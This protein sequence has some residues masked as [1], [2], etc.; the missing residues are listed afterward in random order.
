MDNLRPFTKF[1]CSIGELPTSYVQSLT[2]E[3]QL[4]YFYNYIEEV[5]LPAINNNAEALQET[6]AFLLELKNYVDNYFNNL[7]VQEEINNKLD[8]MAEAGTLEEIISTYLNAQ[9]VLAFDTLDDLKNASNLI[10]GSFVKTYGYTNLNDGE[11]SFYKIR[12]KTEEDVIDDVNIIE[13]DNELLVAVKM[14]NNEMKTFN[15]ISD[16]KS[17]VN[18]SNG[19]FVKTYGFYSINDGG[20]ALYKIRLKTENDNIDEATIIE[21]TDENI[22]A[23]LIINNSL[24]VKQF[25][26]KGDGTTDD[27]EAIQKAIDLLRVY[28]R[29]DKDYSELYFP[30]GEYII[31]DTL[32]FDHSRWLKL[33]GKATIKGNIAK[34]LI[35]FDNAMFIDFNDLLVI[36]QNTSVDSCC[37]YFVDS[38][39][40]AFN[41]AY[42]KGGDIVVYLSNGNDINF[43]NSSIMN[44]R[45][46][47]YTKS[48]ANNTGNNFVNTQIEEASE[49]AIYFDYASPYYGNYNFKG[50]YIECP[51]SEGVIYVKN[52]MNVS[53]DGCYINQKT[54]SKYIFIVDGTIPKMRV[55]LLNSYVIGTSGEVYF[56]KFLSSDIKIGVSIDNTCVLDSSVTLYNDEDT[57]KSVIA[58]INPEI[59]S[60]YNLTWLKDTN[61]TLDT[62]LGSGTYTLTN[63]MSADSLQSVNVTNGYIYKPVYLEKDVL[64]EI[65]AI[66]KNTGSGSCMI[67]IFNDNLDS[68]KMR[69]ESSLST[70]TKI[71]GYYRPVESAVY[72]I[73]I[74][75]NNTT[76]AEFSGIKL[77]SH[78]ID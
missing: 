54:P 37:L 59:L 33:Y 44:G 63:S 48:G 3:E 27:T 45:I 52:R 40:L 4:L 11:G 29:A 8:D 71:T 66:V 64:Y 76:N 13:L 56:S 17:C 74:R 39:V 61:D 68:R 51:S 1:I 16:L 7:D 5:I 31:T 10:N 19:E 22:I 23:E 49:Y 55:K 73:L 58:K 34:P 24:N 77:L 43:N 15:T 20:S 2:Y 36:N 60:I 67:D 32:L 50:C 9:S 14:I 28:P 70:P 69:I 62:W 57:Y 30:N 25:G 18:I 38:Y 75:N 21:L 47:F 6:Q 46:G 12:L 53:F 42:F 41:S 35:K 26:A 72:N 78:K 65:S